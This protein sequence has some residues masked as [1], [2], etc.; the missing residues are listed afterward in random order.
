MV[1]F[2]SYFY[3][4]TCHHYHHLHYRYDV[5]ER[6]LLFPTLLVNQQ[7][8]WGNTVL[9]GACKNN[10]VPVVK[11]VLK[12]KDIAINITDNQ[13][14]TPLVQ[15]A[16]AGNEEVC[17]LLLDANCD[18][19]IRSTET[20]NTAL[21]AA[22]KNGH[23]SIASLLIQAGCDCT[24]VDTDGRNALHMA[25]LRHSEAVIAQLLDNKDIDIDAAEFADGRTALLLAIND[26]KTSIGLKLLEQNCDVLHQDLD[27]HNAI[28]MCSWKGR[29]EIGKALLEQR[30]ECGI[31]AQNLQGYSALSLWAY[32]YSNIEFGSVLL[33]KGHADVNLPNHTQSTPLHVA[34]LRNQLSRVK[35][36]VEHNCNVNTIDEAK[37]TALIHAVSHS[38][39][40]IANYLMEQPGID[41]NHAGDNG[42]TALMFCTM[43]NHSEIAI[44]LIEAGADIFALNNFN[45]NIPILASQFGAIKVMEHITNKLIVK[46]PPKIHP[47]QSLQDKQ[48]EDKKEEIKVPKIEYGNTMHYNHSIRDAFEE[49]A[50]QTTTGT[51]TATHHDNTSTGNPLRKHSTGDEAVVDDLKVDEST[52]AYLNHHGNHGDTAFIRACQYDQLN[53]AKLLVEVGDV[54]IYATKEDGCTGLMVACQ[55]GCTKI[56]EYVLNLY[57]EDEKKE[58]EENESEQNE[59]NT[60]KKASRLDHQ[61]TEGETALM[62]AC[63][64][65]RPQAVEQLLL[66]GVDYSMTN[67]AGQ[68]ASEMASGFDFQEVLSTFGFV[69][70]EEDSISLNQLGD[71]GDGALKPS[72]ADVNIT[73]DY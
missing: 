14:N 64:Y 37:Q 59:T 9:H 17:K 7:N 46:A 15:A 72:T 42:N 58:K 8:L 49:L 2:H 50:L 43:D 65:N 41:I 45:N 30:D 23:T 55:E 73:S 57:A 3:S 5:V 11:A 44:R 29:E 70:E 12:H 10:R 28:M 40:D 48:E 22:I 47:Q 69:E 39:M 20:G 51:T 56:I 19:D 66:A 16:T 68:T 54:D 26:N 34:I 62:I 32:G 1:S 35:V 4:Y 6:L 25:I 18:M 33:E 60:T 53:I 61:N 67:D 63:A 21:L 38:Y 27:G 31:N 13:G 71:V 24:L 52:R 36:L